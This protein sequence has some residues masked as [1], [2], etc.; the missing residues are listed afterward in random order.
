MR[1]LLLS[2]TTGYQAEAFRGAALR[3][4]ATLLLGTDRCH[5]LADPWRDGA[6]PLRFEQPEKAAE[7][8]VEE[9]QEQP[10]DGIVSLGD[11]TVLTAAIAAAQLG[12]PHH[13]PDGVRAALD[14]FATRERFCEAG[15][16]VPAFARLPLDEPRPA[17]P[18]GLEFPCVLKPLGLAGS[19]G[20]IRADDPAQFAAAFERIRR[21]LSLPDLRRLGNEANW[22]QVETYVEGP[23]FALEGLLDRGR[24]KVLALFDKPD[25]LTGPFFEETI[26]LTPSRLSAASQQRIASCTETGARALGLDHGPIHAEMRL[27]QD[28]VWLLEIAPRAIGGLC[29]RTL[30]FGDGVSLEEL[31]IRHALGMPVAALQR[32]QAAAGVMMIPVPAEGVLVEVRGVEDARQVPGVEEVVI[33]ASPKQK[34]VPWPEGNSYPGFIFARAQQVEQVESALRDAHRRLRFVVNTSLPV[35]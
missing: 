33:T 5:V 35:V 2:K 17:L 23:E 12:L 31:L 8:V 7:M 29:A 18:P 28:R 3:L 15:L 14:K 34:L 19:R 10:L 30:R 21:L 22:I 9:T 6:I 27:H 16:P 11:Q 4:G 24:L 20:V 1:L 32:E 26:Y 13:R 25:P